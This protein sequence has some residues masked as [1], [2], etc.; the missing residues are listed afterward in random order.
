MDAR[1]KPETV[2]ELFPR[3]WLCAA[4]LQGRPV[5]VTIHRVDVEDVRQRDGSTVLKAVLT[6]ERAT[7]R[8][9]LNKTQCE[10][11]AELTG[12]ERLAEWVGHSVVLSPGTAPNGKPTIVIGSAANKGEG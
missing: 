9:I 10:A 6:F 2:S 12:T 8:M 11:L 1:G 3:P 5:R 7:K 4:D